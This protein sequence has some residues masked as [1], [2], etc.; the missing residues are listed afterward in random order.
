M[1]PLADLSL[2]YRGIQDEVLAKIRVIIESNAFI[3]GKWVTEFERDFSAAHGLIHAAGCSN[4]TSALHLALAALGI[5]HGDEVIT[6]AMTF[7]AT[8][9]AICH[10]GATPVFV[11]VDPDSLNIDPKAIESA[12]T[13]KTKALLPVHLYGNP[14]D[15]DAIMN[16]AKRN[17]LLVI[18]DCAQAHL[19]KYKG[20][21]VG[22]FGNACTFSFFPGK[23][24]GAYGDAGLVGT[25]DQSR[26]DIVR[27]LLDHGRQSKYEHTVVGY[28]YRMDAIQAGILCVKLTRLASW[29]TARQRIAA[30]Y[31]KTLVAGGF[32]IITIATETDMVY[33][34]FPVHVS[35]RDEAIKMLFDAGIQTGIHY[36]IPLHLQP[37]FKFLGHKKGDLPVAEKAASTILSLP[38]FPELSEEQIEHVIKIFLSVARP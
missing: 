24:L 30:R 34:Q 20:I 29:T 27:R 18:E 38:I 26:M 21:P 6:T 25:A 8:A 36:P 1:I 4:G 17:H 31:S 5:G 2:Q 10:A 22:T 16:V 7:V 13:P 23:N 14:C 28:N 19:A 37:A 15:M 9:E 12:V 35:N 33:H 11:D 3:Q 32:K